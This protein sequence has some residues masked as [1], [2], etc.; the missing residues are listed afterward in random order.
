MALPDLTA[1]KARLRIESDV[2]DDDLTLMMASALAVITETTGR[3]IEATE[4]TW[5]IE[6]PTRSDLGY[7]DRFSLPLYPVEED[8][9]EI[10]DA[11]GDAVTDFRVNLVTGMVVATG[12][13]VFNNF[14]YEVTATVGLDLMDDYATRVEPKLSQALIDL[15]ADWYQRRNPAAIMG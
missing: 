11:D 13:T 6:D 14:P 12:S 5:L 8:S 15:C 1:V 3:P 7:T 4:K 2:E 9:V 10:T